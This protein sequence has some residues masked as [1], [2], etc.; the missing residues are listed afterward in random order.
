MHPDVREMGGHQSERPL[1]ADAEHLLVAGRV[2]LKDRG[3]VLEALGPLGPT[4]GGVLPL[5][6]EDRGAVGVF[7]AFLEV[8]N[9]GRGGLEDGV[10]GGFKCRGGETGVDRD[11]GWE[12]M[13]IVT[14]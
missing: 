1:A 4:A 6:R 2:E 9:L 13:R 10:G 8:G 7:P 14:G 5:D 12:E 3:A 11:H